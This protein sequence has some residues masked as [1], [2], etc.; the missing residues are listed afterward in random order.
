M[1]SY[2]EIARRIAKII[3]S[4]ETAIGFAD[5]VLS[6]PTDIGYLAYGFID[7]DSRYQRE[8]EKIRMFTAIK[9][10]I[11]DNEN[12]LQTIATVLAIFNKSVPEK[13]Q[14]NIYGKVVASV[15]G[16]TVT[17]SVIAGKLA[18]VIAQRSSLLI[19]LRGGMI[20]NLLLAG[21]MAERS[22]Y[23][24]ERLR[25]S[26]PEVYYALRHRNFDLLYFLVEPAL[27][28]FLEALH[29]KRTQGQGAFEQI[30]DM[31]ESELHATT[32]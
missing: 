28:P 6:V 10:G 8:T 18:T 27:N 4:P 15:A 14:N 9:N 2:L 12:F 31:V 26:D 24:S 13:K 19:S 21:G 23:T 1:R 25:Q 20:G 32:K 16:R 22:I 30:L 3:V 17:N 5:G 7:T 29:V 11:L